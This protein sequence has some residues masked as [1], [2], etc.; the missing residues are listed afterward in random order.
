MQLELVG[1]T[2]AGKSTL[3]KR[4][5]ATAQT[6][7]V[8][9]VLGDDF[10]LSGMGARRLRP[11]WLRAIAVH[12]VAFWGCITKGWR[13]V[14]FIRFSYHV[15][16][17]S[18]IPRRQQ[19]NQLRKVFK[20]LGRYEVI[21]CGRQRQTSVLVD[22]GTLH[23][24]HN[25]FVH[26]GCHVNQDDVRKFAERVPLPDVVIYVREREDT[27]VERTLD[28]GHPRISDAT[29]KSVAKFIRTAVQTFEQ[30]YKH[31]RIASRTLVIQDGMILSGPTE[32]STPEMKT[33]FEVLRKA[34]EEGTLSKRILDCKS[35]HSLR[36]NARLGNA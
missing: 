27:L 14:Q 34:I 35:S 4:I 36:G 12:V 19:W 22:E 16:R 33:V 7:G 21:G 25:L 13:H 20:Q 10:A 23:T 1:C 3:A 17:L 6:Q 2:G 29:S 32:L 15:L 8:D 5:A 26:V 24:A 18:K 31:E 30:L 28:R 9:L 11:R